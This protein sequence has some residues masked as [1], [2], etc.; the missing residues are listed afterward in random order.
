MRDGWRV[1]RLA[2]PP[3]PR[4]SLLFVGGRGDFAEKYA[5]TL[6]DWADA[7]RG[8]A[9][10]DHRGQ[11]GSGR[12][13][14]DTQKG[15]APGF[16]PWLADLAEH[17][18]WFRAHY[19]AP[20]FAVAHSM[21]AHLLLRH[22]EARPGDFARAV[23]LSPM[24]GLAA[25]P[26]G[27]WLARRVAEVA[28]AL[29]I[30]E[31]YAPGSGPIARGEPGSARQRL[32]TGDAARYADEGWW[33][34]RHPGLGIGGVTNGW[35]ASAFASM[36]AALAGDRLAGVTTPLLLLAAGDEG[37][38][39]NAATARAAARLR[40]ARLEVIAGAG[41]ELLRETDAIRDAV[42]ARIGAFLA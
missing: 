23:L 19:P 12:F 40:E 11:G 25:K 20:H 31:R 36:D 41:H 33:V 22:L 18:D 32:L 14:A 37:L 29:G 1:R 34:A 8:V 35:L 30:G 38:V 42:L 16:E 17:V 2:L 10:F 39:D 13:L 5:E 6:R 28:C 3:G 24:F 4:G 27:P 7:G 26:V 15:H 21:G 9:T